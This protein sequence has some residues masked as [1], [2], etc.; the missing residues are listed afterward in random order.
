M[1]SSTYSNSEPWQASTVRTILHV[2]RRGRPR[3]DLAELAAVEG[4]HGDR[5]RGVP[6][7]QGRRRRTDELDLR[8]V[9]Q[10]LAP[11]RRR[12]LVAVGLQPDQRAR[13]RRSALRRDPSGGVRSPPW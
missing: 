5:R 10:R 11:A 12:R 2:Q 4:E 3:H 7:A 13:L 9:G 8:G 6:G 1:L